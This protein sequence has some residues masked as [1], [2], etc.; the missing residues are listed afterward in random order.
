VAIFHEK[1]IFSSAKYEITPHHIFL[2]FAEKFSS[3]D[4][5]KMI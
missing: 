1:N 4:L 2:Y 3:Q 5:Q